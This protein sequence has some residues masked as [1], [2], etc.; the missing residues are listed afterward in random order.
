VHWRPAAEAKRERDRRRAPAH[1][2]GYDA[3]WHKLARLVRAEEPLC[4]RC[5]ERGVVTPSAL[6][7]HVAPITRAP[8]LRLER[9]N[10]VAVCVLC[11]GEQHRGLQ[12]AR[13]NPS[14][15]GA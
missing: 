3:A 14:P 13:G 10:L 4:R 7:H 5:L 11:H 8:H 15:Y 1:K 6:V 2:M 9:G 12:A